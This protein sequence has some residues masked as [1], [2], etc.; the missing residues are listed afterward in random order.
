MPHAIGKRTAPSIARR[1]RIRL[2]GP[3]PCARSVVGRKVPT[4]A[5]TALAD[6]ERTLRG[7]PLA[8][9]NFASGARALP[10]ARAIACAEIAPDPDGWI[11]AVRVDVDLDHAGVAWLDAELPPPTFIIRRRSNGHAHLVWELRR[12]VRTGT[13]AERYLQRIRAAYTEACGGDRSYPG[14]FQHNPLA[15]WAWDV[16]VGRAE[17]YTLGE[18][19]VAVDLFTTSYAA[20]SAKVNPDNEVLGR[21]CSIFENVRVAV[22]RT[23][24]LYR[25]RNDYP[26]FEQDVRERV[27]RENEDFPI[28]LPS[29]D[30]RSLTR[31][32]AEW[33]WGY[34]G[35][36]REAAQQRRAAGE[37]R[38]AEYEARAA[39]RAQRIHE[40]RAEGL[41]ATEIAKRVGCSVRLVH[42][43]LA[44]TAQ[45]APLSEL[46][47]GAA[48]AG[49]SPQPESRLPVVLPF[50]IP[51]HP[52]VPVQL[53]EAG[54]ENK[55]PYS[56]PGCSAELNRSSRRNRHQSP[57]GCPQG[58]RERIY[59][60]LTR[61]AVL[62]DGVHDAEL[63][64]RSGPRT[65]LLRS[66][67][68]GEVRGRAF[69]V[70]PE[71]ER[72]SH[73]EVRGAPL[74]VAPGKPGPSHPE[75]RGAA[76]TV[77]PAA[78]SSNGEVR[79]PALA[80]RAMRAAL[81]HREVRGWAR[82]DDPEPRTSP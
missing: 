4:N 12:W 19:A 31:S 64:D 67:S 78:R 22:Y 58:I 8:T 37:L 17:P 79:G 70:A 60:L 48:A 59:A 33:T 66:G 39:L 52:V 7:K 63:R 2:P 55:A 71:S 28:P 65:S 21:N 62:G 34:Y 5:A 32:I 82:G 1:G 46:A 61:T 26:A 77:A 15:S 44:Q 3:P 53:A 18:L 50:R 73:A 42:L 41:G 36:G 56:V 47:L 11:R 24:H 54:L 38:R 25:E 23:V 74:T 14:R 20:P 13:R 9:N 40:L 75:V 49:S 16:R 10:K 45:S 43:R 35:K 27:Q 72:A 76:L 57:S 80:L 29:R 69:T 51:G 30:V 6:F 68:H 81:G